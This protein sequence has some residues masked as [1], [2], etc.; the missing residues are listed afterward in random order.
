MANLSSDMSRQ[1]PLPVTTF[2]ISPAH[3]EL[4]PRPHP[5]K[6]KYEGLVR[7]PTLISAFPST[8]ANQEVE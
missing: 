6:R 7:K 8:S 4:L 2:D 5:A 1:N 3:P